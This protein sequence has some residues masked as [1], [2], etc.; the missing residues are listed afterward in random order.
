MV[1]LKWFVGYIR[2]NLLS[3]KKIRFNF[4][5]KFFFFFMA[6]LSPKE[7]HKAFKVKRRMYK[8]VQKTRIGLHYR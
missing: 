3:K 2:Q 7:L 1:G 5:K 4:F 8:I 6:H